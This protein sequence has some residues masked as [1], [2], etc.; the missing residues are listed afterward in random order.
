MKAT[1]R[2]FSTHPL[3]N[4]IALFFF[5]TALTMIGWGVLILSRHHL[6]YTPSEHVVFLLALLWALSMNIWLLSSSIL[7]IIKINS[8]GISAYSIFWKR[9]I[10]WENLRSVKLLKV[11]NRYARYGTYIEFENTQSPEKQRI[12]IHN[13]GYAVNTFI[14]VSD[15]VWHKPQN[16]FIKRGLYNHRIIAGQHA[17]AFEYNRHAW[18]MI[19]NKRL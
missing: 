3:L 17:I 16:S 18:E 15:K 1:Y 12:A 19:N 2:L 7:P 8:K 6:S 11:K 10:L 4:A 5:L 9:T 13:K 14:I